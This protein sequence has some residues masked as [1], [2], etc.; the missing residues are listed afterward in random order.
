MGKSTLWVWHNPQCSKSR[1]LIRL[2][3]ESKVEYDVR[4]Y[5]E[6]APTEREIREALERLGVPA[7]QLVRKKDKLFQE[8][9]LEDADDEKLIDAMIVYPA[10]IERPLVFRAW[11]GVIA[12]PPERYK[13]LLLPGKK[14]ES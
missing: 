13:E 6:D 3:D 9:D 1:E 8:L 2:L 5:L 4:K 12:R 14:R 10:L 11:R 7:S